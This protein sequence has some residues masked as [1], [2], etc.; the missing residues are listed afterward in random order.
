MQAG[1]RSDLCIG[2]AVTH[3]HIIGADPC[4]IGILSVKSHPPL[5]WTLGTPTMRPEPIL[6]P[7]IYWMILPLTYH[8]NKQ[9]ECLLDLQETFE[10]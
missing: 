7:C 5:K 1:L 6:C 9:G 8:A 10:G 2:C 3:S 4:L